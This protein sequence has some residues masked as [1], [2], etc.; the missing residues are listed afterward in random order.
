MGILLYSILLIFSI[1]Y[2]PINALYE[3]EI[4][5]HDWYYEENTE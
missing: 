3:D 5:S 1:G 2:L 4:G